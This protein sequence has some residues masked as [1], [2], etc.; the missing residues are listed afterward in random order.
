MV[1]RHYEQT[2]LQPLLPH[3]HKYHSACQALLTHK[4]QLDKKMQHLQKS[5]HDAEKEDVMSINA[6]IQEIKEQVAS[7][8]R[9]M[10]VY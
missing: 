7:L 5:L 8:D 6:E 2:Y 3:Y 10:A 9:Q 4:L 1:R